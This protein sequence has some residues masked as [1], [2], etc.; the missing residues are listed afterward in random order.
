MALPRTR[1]GKISERTTQLKRRQ[2]Q[3]ERPRRH[4][5]RRQS[6]NAVGMW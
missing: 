3:G 2:R 4:E 5:H 6:V 1:L